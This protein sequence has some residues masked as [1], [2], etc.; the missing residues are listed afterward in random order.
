MLCQ[1]LFCILLILLLN[2]PLEMTFQENSTS[3]TLPQPIILLQG[4]C[5]PVLAKRISIGPFMSIQVFVVLDAKCLCP[6]LLK[7]YNHLLHNLR[8]I[9]N[10]LLW[11]AFR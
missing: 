3:E 6:C 2:L 1:P 8:I 4:A 11:Y 7:F 9:F 10:V 5:Y